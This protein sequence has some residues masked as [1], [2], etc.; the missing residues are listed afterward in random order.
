MRRGEGL[1]IRGVVRQGRTSLAMCPSEAT[2]AIVNDLDHLC[3]I[4]NALAASV[5]SHSFEIKSLNH[6]KLWNLKMSYGRHTYNPPRSSPTT[7]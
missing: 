3:V 5:Q 6:F 4:C 2:S 1:L 7:V